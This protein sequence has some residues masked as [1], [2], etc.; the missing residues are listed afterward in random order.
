MLHAT[1]LPLPSHTV[2]PLSEQVWVAGA[3]VVEQAPPVHTAVEHTVPVDGQSVGE[4]Q[5]THLPMP[6]QNWPPLSLQPAPI[7]AFVVPHTPLVQVGD[8]HVVDD[9]GHS[10]ATT[11]PTQVP[12]PSQ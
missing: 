10:S 6:S 3:L 12:L 1:H 4:R 5:A 7:M 11:Q 9:E 8:T 2:P